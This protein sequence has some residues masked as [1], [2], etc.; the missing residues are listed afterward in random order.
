MSH[1]TQG[2]TA[3]L[4]SHLSRGFTALL[5]PHLSPGCT[6]VPALSSQGLHQRA[7]CA[8]ARRG[9]AVH[10][11]ASC[12]VA[13]RGLAV[14]WA[15][16]CQLRLA[17]SPQCLTSMA[18]RLPPELGSLR[19]LHHSLSCRLHYVPC[20]LLRLPILGWH[21]MLDTWLLFAA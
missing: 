20:N 7:S 10:Q 9:L 6:S 1:L 2:F 8:V 14:H 3:R 21:P 5:M 13:R 16:T 11:R 17:S 4:M 15:R 12:A 18:R 19:G